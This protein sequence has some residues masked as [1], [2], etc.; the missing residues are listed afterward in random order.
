[1]IGGYAI[2]DVTGRDDAL[3]MARSWPRGGSV[4]VR[5]VMSRRGAARSPVAEALRDALGPAT[6][7]L[8]RALGD[9]HVAED[10]AQD[11]VVALQRWRSDGIPER[12]DLWLLTV[13]RNR[14]VDPWAQ[15][16]LTLRAVCGLTVAQIARAFLISEATIAQRI[17]RAKKI[18]GFG[19]AFG[20]PAPEHLAFR[21]DEVL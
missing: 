14:A 2:V 3:A 20:V 12:P 9:S 18:V 15:V 1:M 10:V 4:E 7:A 8:V 16:A 5:P 17:V 13:A 11:A 19:V 6:G 21:L